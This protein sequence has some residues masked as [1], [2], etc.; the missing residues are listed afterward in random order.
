MFAVANCNY[1]V[2]VRC[3][4]SFKLYWLKYKVTKLRD[5]WEKEIDYRAKLD[6]LAGMEYA[7]C[8]MNACNQILQEIKSMM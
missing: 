7:E 6:G 4:M 5:G 3:A 2:N 8:S 1:Y